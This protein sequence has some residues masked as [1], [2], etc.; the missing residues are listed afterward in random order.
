M[1]VNGSTSVISLNNQFGITVNGDPLSITN[2]V[3]IPL[4]N[5]VVL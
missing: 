1:V 5:S 4:L 2:L 3:G